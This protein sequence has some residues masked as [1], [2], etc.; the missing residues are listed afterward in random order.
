MYVIILL[1][2]I[3]IIVMGNLHIKLYKI[4]LFIP[5]VHYDLKEKKVAHLTDNQ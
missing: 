2:Q 4:I 5:V 1:P 3:R